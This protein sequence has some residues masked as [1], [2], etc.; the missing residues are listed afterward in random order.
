MLSPPACVA[1]VEDVCPGSESIGVVDDDDPASPPEVVDVVSGEAGASGDDC[2]GFAFPAARDGPAVAFLGRPGRRFAGSS[3]GV[4]V[5]AGF[6]S[7]PCACRNPA[8]GSGA[9]FVST[10]FTASGIT[11]ARDGNEGTEPLAFT[12]ASRRIHRW[13]EAVESSTTWPARKCWTTRLSPSSTRSSLKN[14]TSI[15]RRSR[16]RSPDPDPTPRR[17]AARS[18]TASRRSRSPPP[19]ETPSHRW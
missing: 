16:Q 9:R 11:S 6:G 4:S 17:C 3:F 2:D 19:T 15:T 8:K 10:T 14:L 13:A 18:P 7:T 12:A 1:G 5:T